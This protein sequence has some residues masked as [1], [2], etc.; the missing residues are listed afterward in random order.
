MVVKL[1]GE[2]DLYNLGE[3]QDVLS[4]VASLRRPTFIDLS[5]V[6]FAE[7]QTLRELAICSWLYSH[8]LTL[9]NPSWQ[10]RRSIEACG[11]AE[12]FRFHP[13]P[14][15]ESDAREASWSC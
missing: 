13:D 6:T 4:Q 1:L 12:W 9:C 5:G 14:V 2:F 10:V 8:H 15:L 11:L 7:V 3:L